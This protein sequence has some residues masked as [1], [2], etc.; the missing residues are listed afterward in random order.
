M[1][2]LVVAGVLCALVSS[3]GPASSG[4]RRATVVYASGADLQSINPLLTVHPLAKAVQKHVLFMTLATYDVEFQPIPRLAEWVWNEDRTTL[5]FRLRDDVRWHDGVPTRARDVVWTIRSALDPVV[6]YPRRRDLSAITVAREVDSLTV[7][8][9]FER[10]Q[11]V[12]P[13]VLTDLAILPAHRLGE[14]APLELRTA[15]FNRAPVGNGPFRFVEYRP[16]QRWVFRRSE[17]FPADLGRPEVEQF[18]VVVVDEPTTKLA[19]LTSGEL[20]FAG[21]SPAHASFVD[22]DRRLQAIDYPIQLVYAIVWNLRRPPLDDVRVRRALAAALDRRLIVDAYIYGFGTVADGPVPPEHPWYVEVEAIP[23]D[24][25]QAIDLLEQA[26][27]HLGADGVRNNGAERLVIDLMTVGSGDAPLEQMIQAQLRDVGVDVRI[28]QFELTTF[29]A[30]AQSPER[31]F[32]A[33]VTGIPGDF[34]L[35]YVAAMFESTDPGP[36]AYPG[37]GSVDLDLALRRAREVATESEL[38]SAWH[39]IQRILA[40]DHPCTWLYHA[41]GLQGA[42]RR[43]SH[44]VIDLRGELAGIADWRLGDTR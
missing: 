25:D 31:D 35:G 30:R 1:T 23:F 9:R 39:E 33:L 26:G 32:D 14:L 44:A 41:R 3:C 12:F 21:I 17:A 36:L 37:Y 6:A 42:N 22:R 29:L 13:D 5:T 20:D 24:R 18:V 43:I 7:L 19:A 28:H 2:V 16:N 8:L 11:P 38:R 15:Q 27:W 10:P 4:E 40:R 34:S